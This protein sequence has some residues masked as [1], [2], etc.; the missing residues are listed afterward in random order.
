MSDI[1]KI[2]L[3]GHTDNETVVGKEK[4]TTNEQTIQ[5]YMESLYTET[6]LESVVYQGYTATITINEQTILYKY[7]K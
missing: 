6:E 7:I 5:A 1:T 4:G 2:I 3:S